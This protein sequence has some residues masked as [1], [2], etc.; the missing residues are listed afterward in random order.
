MPHIPRSASLDIGT[1]KHHD[2]ARSSSLPEYYS[3]DFDFPAGRLEFD[4]ESWQQDRDLYIAKI[5][6]MS[7][8]GQFNTPINQ[9]S[10]AIALSANQPGIK[11]PEVVSGTS[12]PK[13]E[14]S[15]RSDAT[16][17]H[18]PT[19]SS[20]I[21]FKTAVSPEIAS[22]NFVP[23]GSNNFRGVKSA[24]T[25]TTKQNSPESIEESYVDSS[26]LGFELPGPLLETE[27]NHKVVWALTGLL[28]LSI[29]GGIIATYYAVLGSA[30]ATYNHLSSMTPGQRSAFLRTYGFEAVAAKPAFDLEPIVPPLEGARLGPS[31]RF[32]NI[33]PR[34]KRNPHVKKWMT[35]YEG[36]PNFYGLAYSPMNAM[37]PACGVTLQDV[38]QDLA[39]MATVTSR[40]RTYG[41]QCN[42]AE[43][44]L[45][46]IHDMGLNMTL[47]MGVWIGSDS[48]V[49]SRQLQM[50]ES[51][52]RRY[53]SRYFEAIFIGNE[54][55]FRE[56]KTSEQLVEFITSTKDLLKTLEK[57]IPVGTAEIGSL[58]NH[59]ILAACDIVGANIH[60]FFGGGDVA[61]ATNWTYEFVKD[62]IPDHP[63]VVITE[64]GWPYN[65]GTF[66][67]A[68]ASPQA[69]KHFM[70][71]YVCEAYEHDYGWYY[72]EAF[73]EPWKTVFYEN[74]HQW[75]T[76]WGVFTKDRVLKEVPPVCQ[77]RNAL[78]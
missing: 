32:E 64:V 38:V 73:D 61:Q 24:S 36:G 40:I 68:T 3:D 14:P 39:A 63:N 44:I 47:A 42:Q 22:G 69:F 12:P 33:K 31:N 17:L 71:D 20:R 53:P 21:L 19:E 49:N 76:E 35:A 54:V 4:P 34:Y 7:L 67:G 50:M 28:L 77:A 46:L 57:S 23:P 37:E 9:Q 25:Q 51:V 60:P 58:L 41:M 48:A 6:E 52:L 72:F 2:Q 74:N 56:E 5:N 59:Q 8:A 15:D 11:S 65:G 1:P 45:Q 78:V 30:T 75:E 27:R 13:R 66:M 10:P 43:Y 16:V 18:V 62:Q 29:L 70:H 55:L 26:D